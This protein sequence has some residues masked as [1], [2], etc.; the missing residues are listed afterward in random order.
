[1]SCARSA[2]SKTCA[3]W[4][5]RYRIAKSPF[6]RPPLEL[7][8]RDAVQH[9]LG[10]RLVVGRGRDADRLAGA[11]IAPE[12]LFEELRIVADE[13]VRA[14]QDAHRRAVVLL[15]L[16]DLDVG[17]VARQR[18]KVV[19]GCASPAVDR[20]VVVAHRRKRR[21]VPDEGPQQTVL[22]RIRVL[23]LVD[24]DMR[25]ARTPARSGLRIAFEQRE[26]AHDEVVEVHGAIRSERLG[27]NCNTRVRQRARRRS[28]RLQ[29]LRPA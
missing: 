19:D 17:I 21:A 24:Q 26:R 16:D 27:R 14:A 7:E 6:F 11:E 22:R 5:P 4:L 20:L 29:G 25:A 2:V 15:E 9:H 8:R 23:V 3:W 10:F 13:R 1:M 18:G 12:L 28:A